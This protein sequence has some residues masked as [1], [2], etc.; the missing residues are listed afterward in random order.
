VTVETRYL[1]AEW[2]P[3]GIQAEPK[4]GTPR[5]LIFHTMVGNLRPV[6]AMFR[7]G[8]YSGVESH[9]GLGGP[10]EP[11]D[12]D[13]VLWQ[14]QAIDRQADAQ[15]DGNAYATSVETADGGDPDRPW[16]DK[17]VTALVH[18]GIWWCKQ[19]GHPLRLVD[20]PSEA[21]FGYHSQF[22]AWNAD[23]HTCPN[24]TRIKQLKTVVIPRVADALRAG[25]P[26]APKPTPV[27]D[28][29]PLTDAEIAKVA[30]A[31]ANAVVAETLGASGPNVGVALQSTY[32][33]LARLED[34]VAAIAQRL[35]T[36]GASSGAN[37]PVLT[38]ADIRAELVAALRSVQ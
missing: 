14:W 33:R 1:G 20:L 35:A 18:L 37:G 28:D 12:L 2:R 26:P 4:I 36:P 3:L 15:G 38:R 30:A 13:G 17:Q 8:G 21:G 34:A 32:Q 7:K 6:D 31:A 25:S 22:R 23:R 11:G 19:T 10:W 29:M 27:E 9:F 5:V 16:T 24:P